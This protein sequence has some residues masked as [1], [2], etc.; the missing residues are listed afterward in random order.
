MAID[1]TLSVNNLRG[2]FERIKA[3][4]TKNRRE[5]RIPFTD[6][7][8]RKRILKIIERFRVTF[9]GKKGKRGFVPRDQFSFNRPLLFITYT[10]KLV[11]SR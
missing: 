7:T 3:R 6:V 2:D 8:M 1:T 9:Y 4:F 11:V 10:K 5:R